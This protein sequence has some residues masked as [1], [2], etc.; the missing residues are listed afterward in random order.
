MSMTI[1]SVP[2][3]ALLPAAAAAAPTEQGVAATRKALDHQELMG[4]AA[5]QLIEES[6]VAPPPPE[7]ARGSRVSRVA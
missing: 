3:A 1:A 7:P 2:D 6:A 4:R 5:V